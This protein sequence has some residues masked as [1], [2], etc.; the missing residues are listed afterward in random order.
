MTTPPG[1]NGMATKKQRALLKEARTQAYKHGLNRL[2]LQTVARN[3]GISKRTLYRYYRNREA[4][5]AAVMDFDG[6]AWCEWFFDAI[7]EQADM[8]A[9]RLYA[10]FETLALWEQSDDFRGCLFACALFNAELMTDEPA[11]VARHYAERIRA[12]ISEN[13]RR[14]GIT[15]PDDVAETLLLPT[16]AVLSGTRPRVNKHTGHH[17]LT[18]ATALLDRHLTAE[19]K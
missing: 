17:L 19:N 8:P 4:F 2:S 18:L 6:A 14:A 7:R 5:L 9:Q 1:N 10:F 15:D 13:M 16:L 3:T 12:F 11:A